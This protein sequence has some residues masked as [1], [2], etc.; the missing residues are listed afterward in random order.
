[1]RNLIL[2]IAL[3][4][5]CY[6]LE[7]NTNTN[8]IL[9]TAKNTVT[10]KDVIS[11][12]TIRQALTR[13]ILIE[14]MRKN[15]KDYPIYIVLNSPGGSVFAGKEFI[16]F[17]NT[18][19]NV[20]TICLYCASMAHGISQGV[21][22]TRFATYDN[23]MMAHRAS[24]AFSGQFEYGEVESRLRM[25]KLVIRDLERQNARRLKISLNKY[26]KKVV[27]EWWTYGKESKSQN[28]VDKLVNIKCS[29]GL[30]R[31]PLSAENYVATNYVNPA[32]SSCP[33]LN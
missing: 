11:R 33:L 18:L 3:I 6:K 29:K 2:L 5:A 30:I 12:S 4:M 23:I 9:L 1:M 13:L 27:N 8:T 16:T 10:I 21:K 28:V 22:G 31:L 15:S 26:K 17:V 19:D 25:Y 24:G 7:A 14:S 20:H 32:N